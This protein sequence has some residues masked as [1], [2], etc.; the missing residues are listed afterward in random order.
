MAMTRVDYRLIADSLK[1]IL[2]SGALDAP[3]VEVI[4]QTLAQ[5]IGRENVNFNYDSFMSYIHRS[6]N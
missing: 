5:N 2:D 1:E 3:S 4:A 6:T